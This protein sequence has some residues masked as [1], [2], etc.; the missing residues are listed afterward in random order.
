MSLVISSSLSDGLHNVAIFKTSLISLL[1]DFHTDEAICITVF[2]GNLL[3]ILVDI[4][5]NSGYVYSGISKTWECLH[6]KSTGNNIAIVTGRISGII[7]FDTDGQEALANFN[8]AVD[9]Q[10]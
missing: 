7:A 6:R 2:W 5:S 4:S 9:E 3:T 8:R 10:G 1:P